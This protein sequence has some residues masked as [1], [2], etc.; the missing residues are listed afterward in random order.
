MKAVGDARL[1][2]RELIVANRGGPGPEERRRVDHLDGRQPGAV[3]R[4]VHRP[5]REPAQRSPPD[6]HRRDAFARGRGAPLQ[7]G[8]PQQRV[9]FKPPPVV[10]EQIEGD[11]AGGGQRLADFAVGH[12]AYSFS[13]IDADAKPPNV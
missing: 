3:E 5:Q 6:A 8:G 7:V 4:D 9:P 10:V 1:V 13:R 12:A 2:R 11:R